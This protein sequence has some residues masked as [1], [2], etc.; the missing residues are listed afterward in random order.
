MATTDNDNILMMFEEINQKLDRA[1]QQIEKI[2]QK[3]PEETGNE[4][5]L[6]LK[7]VMEDF[8]ESQSEK[9]NEIEN[10]VRK[11]K[12]KI[13]FTPNSVNTII[14]LLSLMVFVLGFLWWNARLHEQLAQYADNDLK[15]RY[16]LMQGKTT[17]ETLSHL[18]NIFESK[19]DSAKIIRKQVENYEKNL[20]E[21]IKLLNKARLK[22]QE[23]ER[24]REELEILRNNK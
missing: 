22:E 14:V 2:G 5:I 17:P 11:E 8:H 3:Q 24:V 9:L 18:E 10:A 23:A 15:Y 21:E 4:Q 7:T 20:M 6:E 13:E 19:S 1:N 16:I 12:R